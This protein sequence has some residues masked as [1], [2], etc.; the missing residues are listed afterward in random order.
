MAIYIYYKN[1]A[2]LVKTITKDFTQVSK[3]DDDVLSREH[4]ICQKH[5]IHESW[6][7][8]IYR[9]KQAPNLLCGQNLPVS[10]LT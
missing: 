5:Q 1:Q 8:I 2:P 6:M 3:E 9:P 7:N 4:T 10:I